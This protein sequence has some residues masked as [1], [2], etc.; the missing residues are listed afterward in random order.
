MQLVLLLLCC[1]LSSASQVHRTVPGVEYDILMEE[2]RFL[3]Y[4]EIE[5]EYDSVSMLY[6]FGE[7][8][9]L[10]GSRRTSIFISLPHCDVTA[11]TFG[12]QYVGSTKRGVD[13]VLSPITTTQSFDVPIDGA[14][15]SAFRLID[16]HTCYSP[17]SPLKGTPSK[18]Y[19]PNSWDEARLLTGKGWS[20]DT[21]EFVVEVVRKV[22][23][24]VLAVLDSIGVRP[25]EA[26]WIVPSYGTNPTST[27]F[28]VT[29]PPTCNGETVFLRV[30]SKHYGASTAEISMRRT[31]S[32]FSRSV[33]YANQPDF[34]DSSLLP[35]YLDVAFSD[36]LANDR[37]LAVMAYFNR[38]YDSTGCEPHVMMGISW[39]P[40]MY[41]WLTRWREERGLDRISAACDAATQEGRNWYERTLDG[42]V[43][44]RE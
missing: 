19:V 25:N 35:R 14:S 29:L 18:L 27:S 28:R 24:Q 15:I 38:F 40:E 23:G 10:Q 6:H 12:R 5:T 30:M 7:V 21:T 41:A 34:S 31:H 13:E 43:E 9:L 26:S 11:G 32:T 1:S 20:K 39:S 4:Y 22:D 42:V 44:R 16:Y 36:T 2:N 33:L 8:E 17:P 3:W 37:D